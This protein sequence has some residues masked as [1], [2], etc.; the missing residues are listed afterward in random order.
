MI[1]GCFCAIEDIFPSKAYLVCARNVHICW[2]ELAILRGGGTHASELGGLQAFQYVCVA[3]H[4]CRSRLGLNWKYADLEPQIRC[5]R[6]DDG[7]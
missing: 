1:P 5:H 6:H 2:L 7:M 4:K 3:L